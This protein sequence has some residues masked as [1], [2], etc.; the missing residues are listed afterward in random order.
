MVPPAI[1]LR[2]AKRL[3][4]KLRLLRLT[5]SLVAVNRRQIDR[6]AS[7]VVRAIVQVLNSAVRDE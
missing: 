3:T 5:R 7:Q 4:A 1:H 6:L 2:K